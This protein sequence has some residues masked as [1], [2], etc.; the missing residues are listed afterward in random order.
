MLLKAVILFLAVM[1]LLAIFGN[2]NASGKKPAPK[3]ME[4]A[5]KC[6]DCGSY[7]IG[8]GDCACGKR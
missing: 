8:T 2:K 4:S 6:P 3:R 7:R 1:G 5:K